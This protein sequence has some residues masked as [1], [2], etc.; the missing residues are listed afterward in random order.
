MRKS[1]IVCAVI[2]LGVF[3][4]AQ[5]AP[6]VESSFH[7]QFRINSYLQ[8]ASDK[9]TFGDADKVGS[10]LR[11]RPTWDVA[12][13]NG[14][15]LHLQLNIGHIDSNLTQS[16]PVRIRHGVVSTP[17]PFAE[18]W[19][20]AGGLIPLSDKFGDTLFSGDWDFNPL[21]FALL[22]KTGGLDIRF[23]HGNVLEGTHQVSD[24][25]DLWLLDI[26]SAA[27]GFGISAYR[28]GNYSGFN[29]QISDPPGPFASGFDKDEQYY[30]GARYAR[31]VG[32]AAFNA[33]AVYNSGQRDPVGGGA[34]VDNDGWAASGQ[35]KLPVG[36]AKVG[37]LV[38]Y[39][40]GD[41][42]YEAGLDSDSFITPMSLY[43]GT[44]YWGYTGQLNVQ[45]PTDTKIDDALVNIDGGSAGFNAGTPPLNLGRGIL[46]VQANASFNLIP[47][48]LDGYLA[49][50]W[51]Q[52]DDE[53]TGF[54]DEIG[55]DV[56]A[57]GNYHFGSG[58]NLEFGVDYAELGKGHFGS[59]ALG[60][61]AGKERDMFLVFS[62]FQ[63]EY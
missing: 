38:V 25:I 29:Q 18:D 14:V 39:A 26:D 50:G 17:L 60:S 32:T 55:W 47:D 23:G 63:L 40:S 16:D 7:G 48:E 8:D 20:L 12:F 62:R 11:Y 41:E 49:V 9:E 33:W 56:I 46:T 6:A 53:P 44:G 13:D 22:G 2:F 21:T 57:M 52:S 10:R 3:V 24:D 15:K 37:F 28:F 61:G 5:T 43:G 58:L 35:V 59:T 45:G 54:D 19:T 31:E 1:L 36:A 51:Y 34:S 4:Y 42:D 27:T 30:V